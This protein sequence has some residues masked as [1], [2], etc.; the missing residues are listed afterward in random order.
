ME[1]PLCNIS[2]GSATAKLLRKAALIV[3]DEANMAH[4]VSVEALVKTLRDIREDSRVIG[5]VILLMSGDLRQRLA[6]IPT[7]TK[8]DEIKACIKSS[9]LWSHVKCFNLTTNMR[10]NLSGDNAIGMFA[11]K[12]LDIGNG[13]LRF[14]TPNG[15]VALNCRQIRDSLEELEEKVFPQIGKITKI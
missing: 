9:Y 7:E 11:K 4:P 15:D 3:S 14:V 6:V 10:V 5:G 8:A 13:K 1:E 12:L 2:R